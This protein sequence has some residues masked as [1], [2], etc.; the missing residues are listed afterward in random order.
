MGILDKLKSRSDKTSKSSDLP[1]GLHKGVKI[2]KFQKDLEP[3][4]NFKRYLSFKF[5]KFDKDGNIEGEHT[6]S[7]FAL[8]LSSEYL[9]DNFESLLAQTCSIAVAIYGDEWVKH[10]D[11]LKGVLDDDA[12]DE[13]YEFPAIMSKIKDRKFVK[14]IEENVVEQVGI[15]ID[16]Y[17]ESD[18]DLQFNLKLVYNKKGKV[19]IGRAEFLESFQ[20]DSSS[21]LNLSDYEKGLIKKHSK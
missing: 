7:F 16:D 8:D 4:K 9:S 3:I 17:M 2:V 21:I 5:K 1:G 13:D 19:Q 14:L 12:P 20:E 6:N 18:E 10:F 15:F 11:P